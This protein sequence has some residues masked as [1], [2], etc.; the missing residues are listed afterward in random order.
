MDASIFVRMNVP[1]ILPSIQSLLQITQS[2]IEKIN[3][4]AQ[5]TQYGNSAIDKFD[6][7]A[8]SFPG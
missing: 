7:L 8:S 5:I 1:M 2:G 4:G 3:H 6:S